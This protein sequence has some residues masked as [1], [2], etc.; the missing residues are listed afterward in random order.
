LK[1]GYIRQVVA[2]Y[3]FNYDEMHIETKLKVRSHNTNYCLIEVVTITGLTNTRY[4][5]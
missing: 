5:S 2:K 4:T 3:R 1:Y